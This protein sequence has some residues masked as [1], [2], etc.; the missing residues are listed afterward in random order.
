MFV[1][2]GA[3]AVRHSE[4]KVKGAEKVVRPLAS[5]IPNFPDDVEAVVKFNGAVQIGAGI[6]LAMGKFKRVAAVALIGSIIPTTYAGHRFW[7]EADEDRRAQQRIHFLKNLGLLGGLIFAIDADN[8]SK[9]PTRSRA[10]RPARGGRRGTASTTLTSEV[11][12]TA[13]HVSRR[14]AR[15][16]KRARKVAAKAATS[17][18]AAIGPAMSTVTDGAGELLSW[19][20][21]HLGPA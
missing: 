6:L 4:S 8:G 15:S 2:G 11:R 1:A 16:A 3:D 12:K 14:A 7:E 20:H 10:T 9:N 5:R 18:A 19:A 13:E 17:G 21:D